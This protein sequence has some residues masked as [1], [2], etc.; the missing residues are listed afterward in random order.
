[1]FSLM[2][3]GAIAEP[4]AAPDRDSRCSP[5]PVSATVGRHGIRDAGG[6]T[7]AACGRGDPVIPRHCPSR[8]VYQVVALAAV[9]WL[10]GLATAVDAQQSA[11]PRRIGVLLNAS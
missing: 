6:L 11:P 7:H 3:H 10:L 5:R 1:M 8:F 2:G 4:R 9:F